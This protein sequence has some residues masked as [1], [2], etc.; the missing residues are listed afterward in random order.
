MICDTTHSYVMWLNQIW[1]DSSA[2]D[3]LNLYTCIGLGRYQLNSHMWYFY[4][5][6]ICDVHMWHSWC[7]I[8][9]LSPHHLH[10]TYVTFIRDIHF[11]VTRSWMMFQMWF[12]FI[13]STRD[14]CDIYT[15]HSF[16]RDSRQN[17]CHITSWMNDVSL[18]SKWMSHHITAQEWTNRTLSVHERIDS[19]FL[20]LPGSEL[21]ITEIT[22]Y[23]YFSPLKLR[24]EFEYK[25]V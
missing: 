25:S 16:W 14:I 17:E 2:G 6:F 11:D 24:R 8:C 19:R 1:Y 15:W 22:E 10:V 21:S 7:F 18:T 5:I 9:E 13:S 3:C 12:E 23:I 20:V 4:V